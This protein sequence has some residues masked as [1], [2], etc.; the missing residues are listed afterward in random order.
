MPID[1]EEQ[2]RVRKMVARLDHTRRMT[3]VQEDCTKALSRK[4]R[5]E[6]IVR[7]ATL[8]DGR[9]VVKTDVVARWA[10]GAREFECPEDST[11]KVGGWL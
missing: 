7:I 3:A 5:R 6:G 10:P 4:F 9:T 2:A 1:Y 8:V 11:I